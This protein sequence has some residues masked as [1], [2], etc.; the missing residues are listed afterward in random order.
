MD[1]LHLVLGCKRQASLD[2]NYQLL[3]DPK[4][5]IVEADPMAFVQNGQFD[6]LLRLDAML[7]K[8]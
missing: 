2:L 6:L 7:M 1:K 4:I 3:F 5:R 8:F